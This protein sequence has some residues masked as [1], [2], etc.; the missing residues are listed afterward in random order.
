[1]VVGGFVMR[2]KI[3]WSLCPMVEANPRLQSGAPVL[4]GT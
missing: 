1:M 3:D 2:D 4:R